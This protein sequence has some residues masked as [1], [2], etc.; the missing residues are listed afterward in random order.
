MTVLSLKRLDGIIV[1]AYDE[2]H[3]GRYLPPTG[4]EIRE[5]TA[6]YEFLVDSE[7]SSR[8]RGSS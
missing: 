5:S 6:E 8:K 3:R 4:K 2:N 1:E 7:L